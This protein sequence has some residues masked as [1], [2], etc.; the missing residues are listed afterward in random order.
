MNH[1]E[2]WTNQIQRVETKQAQAATD[3]LQPLQKRQPA[4]LCGHDIHGWEGE[5]CANETFGHYNRLQWPEYLA[6]PEKRIP[7]GKGPSSWLAIK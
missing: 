6:K 5:G 2:K 7:Y 3:L 1:P 4:L